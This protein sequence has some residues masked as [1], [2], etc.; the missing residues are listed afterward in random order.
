MASQCAER[1]GVPMASQC[2]ERIGV[3][4][5][6]ADF[7]LM[8]LSVTPRIAWCNDPKKRQLACVM[9]AIHVRNAVTPGNLVANIIALNVR[10]ARHI[11][12]TSSVN[13]HM[14]MC[15]H[16]CSYSEH[17]LGHWRRAQGRKQT[18]KRLLGSSNIRE[19]V[20]THALPHFSEYH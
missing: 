9:L 19:V 10:E 13:L 15:M 2:A 3:S 12:I 14:C 5:G 1:I 20:H 8:P 7:S 6:S 18:P 4:W 16:A 11:A 17:A